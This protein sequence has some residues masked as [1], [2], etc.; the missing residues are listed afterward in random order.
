MCKL[1]N[2]DNCVQDKTADVDADV[3]NKIETNAE[4]EENGKFDEFSYVGPRQVIHVY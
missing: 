2:C 3:E 4:E 1:K